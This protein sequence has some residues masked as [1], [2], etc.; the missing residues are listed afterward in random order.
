MPGTRKEPSFFRE[1]DKGFVE[2][3][4]ECKFY[5]FHDEWVYDTIILFLAG[6]FMIF[7]H[8]LKDSIIN[9]EDSCDVT[10]EIWIKGTGS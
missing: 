2:I 6:E 3:P 1:N 5:G 9:S 10:E 4:R 8:I 7:Y